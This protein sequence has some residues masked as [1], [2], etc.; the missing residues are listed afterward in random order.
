MDLRKIIHEL[1]IEKERLDEAILALEK[2]SGRMGRRRRSSHRDGT[3]FPAGQEH[4]PTA[5]EPAVDLP[6]AALGK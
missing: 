2:L 6:A 1:E 5:P 4:L 3:P